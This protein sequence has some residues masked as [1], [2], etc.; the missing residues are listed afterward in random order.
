MADIYLTLTELQEVFYNLFTSMFNSSPPQCKFR[1]SWPTQG[2]PA[3]KVSDDVA[4][5]KLYDIEGTLTGQ[6]EDSYSQNSGISNM[7]T[8][9]T[10]VLRLDFIFYGPESWENATK[11]RNQIYWQENHDVLAL[12]NLYLIPKF[13]P[14]R[15]VPEL[16]Q[17]QWYERSDL[18]MTFN[19]LVVLNREVPYIEKVQVGVFDR[20]GLRIETDVSI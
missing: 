19:E 3:F 10:R 16:W 15:R 13:E 8:G 4:F 6:R 9:Y 18:S 12:S 14:P 17:G 5:L 20:K 1:W 2:A 7:A 11:V